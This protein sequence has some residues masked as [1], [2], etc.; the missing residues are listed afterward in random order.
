[1]KKLAFALVGLFSLMHVSTTQAQTADDVVSKYILAIGGADAWKKVNSI[2]MEGN[3]SVQGTDVNVTITR[4]HLKGVRTDIAVMGMS[5]YTILTPSAGWNYFPFQGQTA[6]E[7]IGADDVKKAQDQL[8]AQGPLL[9][10]Q[11][12]GHK[13]ELQGTEDIDGAK[14]FKLKVTLSSGRT[15]TMFIEPKN[16]YLVQTIATVS[17]GGQEAEQTIKFSNFQKLPEGIV[18]PMTIGQTQGEVNITKYEVN[19]PVDESIF[20]AS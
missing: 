8:D 3:L 18:V 11:A 4:L 2:R 15:Q 17:M 20:K 10:Y 7:A 16:Y 12:K 9:D 19:K 1:M 5:G 6:P 13:V 14:C